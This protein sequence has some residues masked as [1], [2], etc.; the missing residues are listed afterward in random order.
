MWVAMLTIGIVV[1]LTMMMVMV[2]EVT[3]LGGRM[4]YPNAVAIA[5]HA[6][7]TAAALA[8]HSASAADSCAGAGRREQR[9]HRD[10]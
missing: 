3:D 10:T 2:V 5:Q 9:R 4:E 6:P 8:W 7:S 1:L